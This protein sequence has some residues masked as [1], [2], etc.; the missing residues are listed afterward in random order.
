MSSTIM[1]VDDSLMVRMQVATTLQHAGYEVVEACDGA[2]AL[3]KLRRTPETSLVVLD[4]NMPNMNGIEL[5]RCLRALSSLAHVPVVMLT[6]EGH[7]ELM[8]EAKALGARGWIVK[9]FK[10]EALVA[11]VQKLTG[12]TPPPVAPGDRAQSR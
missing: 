3:S 11:A 4:V 9:P 10:S 1:V 2:E 5:L 6:T 8:R 12:L 7:P